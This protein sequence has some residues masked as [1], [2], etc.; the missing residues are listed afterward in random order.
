MIQWNFDIQQSVTPT[1]LLDI[2]YAGSHGVHLTRD[3]QMNQLDPQ[4]LSLGTGL[5]ALVPN[6]FASFVT[7][8]PLS[9]P[10]VARQQLLLP[11]PQF[12]SVDVINDTSASSIYDSLQI[13]AEKRLSHGVSFL[14]SYTNG[15]LITDTNTQQAPIGGNQTVAN[16][17]QNY[18]DLKAERGL[19]ELDIAQSLVFNFVANLPFG[20]SEPLFSGVHGL[21][22]K[23]ISGWRVDGI[24]TA[25]SG[26]P[27][28]ISTS[29][30]HGGNRPNSTGVSANLP[31]SRPDGEKVAEWFN[32]DAFTQ[33]DPFTFGN[34]GRT[35]GNV[36]GPAF[37][38]LDLS[39]IKTTHIT[40]RIGFEFRAEAFNVF[41]NPHFYLPDTNLQ[42]AGFGT[43]TS[44]VSP[45]REI[46]FALELKF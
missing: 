19:S 17:T 12:T 8:G 46:Q 24:V 38:N 23:L 1:V 22:E 15:K 7:T 4:Y 43:I 29:I 28:G 32:T 34:V 42:D 2:G 33:P 14:L 45:P 35:L 25:H 3:F 39:M 6:P 41:N 10:E 30:P 36:R 18:Y 40:E 37:V 16:S 9:Q 21:P 13:K 20:T 5:Q 11:Y 27:L 26:F 44:T 31:T